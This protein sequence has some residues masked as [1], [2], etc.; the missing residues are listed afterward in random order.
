MRIAIL[1][2][3]ARKSIACGTANLRKKTVD[4]Y[5]SLR[6]TLSLKPSGTI[7]FLSIASHMKSR[8]SRHE[9][10][11]PPA[12]NNVGSRKRFIALAVATRDFFSLALK[13]AESIAD[14]SRSDINA[15]MGTQV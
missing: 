8:V 3:Y 9:S 2:S 6:K 5:P 11:D 14:R 1:V 13:S 7:P 4:E 15:L 12:K 10:K